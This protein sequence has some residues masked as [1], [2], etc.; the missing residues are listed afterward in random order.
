[1]PIL[2]V[3]GALILGSAGAAAAGATAT[4]VVG[5]LAIAGTAAAIGTY[6]YSESE[7]ATDAK[8]ADR[9]LRSNID[10][11]RRAADAANGSAVGNVTGQE[12]QDTVAKRM[13]RAG[14]YFTS[15]LG[16]TSN[17]SSA[18]QKVFS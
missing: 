5:G 12:A 14:S 10:D 16:D 15:P 8:K 3:I 1:M 18:S 11:Q 17:V 6:A 13:A 9:L 4:A 2:P 7:K